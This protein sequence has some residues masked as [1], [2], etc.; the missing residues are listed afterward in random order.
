MLFK[1]SIKEFLSK[2]IVFFMP[3]CLSLA[4]WMNPHFFT[5][6]SFINYGDMAFP[7]DPKLLLKI[8]LY[9]YSRGI[10]SR[11]RFTSPIESIITAWRVIV[12]VNIARS[13]M[14]ISQQH[15]HGL[16]VTV[17]ARPHHG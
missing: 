3:L 9:A 11:P 14:L 10:V 15:I 2:N 5:P 8:V 17:K 6:E 7:L 12:N 13:K 4:V 1:F 16:A